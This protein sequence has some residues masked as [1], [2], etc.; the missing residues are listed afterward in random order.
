MNQIE[1]SK[2]SSRLPLYDVAKGICIISVVMGHCNIFSRF[3]YFYHIICF[4]FISGLFLGGEKYTFKIF[5]LKRIKSLYVPYVVLSILFALLFD[6]KNLLDLKYFI[7][8]FLFDSKVPLTGAFWFIPCLFINSSI[9]FL[10][11]KNIKQIKYLI[12]ILCIFLC[13]CLFFKKLEIHFY[14]NLQFIPWIQI[15]FILALLFKKMKLIKI[16][17][18]IKQKIFLLCISIIVYIFF[19]YFTNVKIDVASGTFSNVLVWFLLIINAVI[20]VF[21][22]SSF[23]QNVRLFSLIGEHSF[24]I[25]CLHFFV[26][27][28]INIVLSGFTFLDITYKIQYKQYIFIYLLLGV[29]IP[30]FI[31][32]LVSFIKRRCKKVLCKR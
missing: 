4:F 13:L 22:I 19:Y 20:F 24:Y 10:I 16:F 21:S 11:E 18:T 8:I 32:I 5:L 27:A 29:I 28:M 14:Y 2:Q 9:A 23:A 1:A 7:R 6:F 30:L 25:M 3:V 12:L 26:F 15:I 31:S 17:D